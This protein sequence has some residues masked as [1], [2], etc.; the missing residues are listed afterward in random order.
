MQITIEMIAEAVRPQFC[1]DYRNK[2][3]Q[4]AANKWFSIHFRSDRGMNKHMGLIVIFALANEKS[5][6]RDAVISFLKIEK[7]LARSIESKL[8]NINTKE[9]QDEEARLFRRKLGLARNLLQITSL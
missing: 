5:I 6:P 4:K 3:S 9:R 2:N 8:A 7:S 1:W